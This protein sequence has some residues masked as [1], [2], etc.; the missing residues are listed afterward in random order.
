[1]TLIESANVSTSSGLSMYRKF[2]CV[3][4][5]LSDFCSIMD[6]PSQPKHTR[7]LTPYRHSF[8]K[9]PHPNR[10]YGVTTSCSELPQIFAG[11]HPTLI[12]VTISETPAQVLEL[13]L[14][15]WLSSRTRA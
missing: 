11:R 10:A 7:R 9:P 6:F 14:S 15:Q 2:A 13:M 12:I 3:G 4:G 1:M 8:R 5:D